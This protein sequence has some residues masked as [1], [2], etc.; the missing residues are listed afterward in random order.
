LLT[1]YTVVQQYSERKVTDFI[2]DM[3][4]LIIYDCDCYKTIK[5]GQQKPKILQKVGFL[6][7]GVHVSV[8]T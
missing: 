5:I 2:S 7:H 3:I 1:L 6:V 8:H 4:A